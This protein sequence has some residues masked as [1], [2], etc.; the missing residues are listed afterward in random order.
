MPGFTTEG[1]SAGDELLAGAVSGKDSHPSNDPCGASATV[2]KPTCRVPDSLEVSAYAVSEEQV[3]SLADDDQNDEL[4]RSFDM[5]FRL[6]QRSEEIRS[7]LERI[8]RILLNARSVAALSERIIES[9]EADLELVAVRL[10]FKD[11]HPVA[12]VFRRNACYGVGVIAED[13]VDNEGL[14]RSDPFILDDP[15]GNLGHRLFGDSASLIASAAVAPLCND[16]EELGLLCLGSNDPCRYCGGMNTELIASMADKISLGIRN[17]WDHETALRR[18]FKTAADGVYTE[19]FF[20]EYLEKQFNRG[21]R[22]GSTFSVLAVSW[23]SS[24]ENVQSCPDGEVIELLQGHLR[25]SDLVAQGETVKLWVLLPDTDASGAEVVGKRLTDVSMQYFDG[26]LSVHIG[27][28]E[29]SR[30]F[31]VVSTLIQQA[32]S[33]LDEALGHDSDH[34][35]VKTGLPAGLFLGDPASQ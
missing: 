26:D 15:S 7:H 6:H 16:H 8:D 35:V 28:T 14:F 11:D 12:S 25:S 22:H 17:A 23:K 21:W 2:E 32:R 19:A 27:I 24:C 13:F 1:S 29:F 34:L 5:I 31:P 33:A 20:R 30:S 10:L 18:A 3:E 4:I 9:L